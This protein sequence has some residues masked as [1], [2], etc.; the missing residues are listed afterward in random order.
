MRVLWTLSAEQDRADIIDFIA[1]NN[2]LAAVRM[3]ELF[4]AAVERLANH[5]LLGPFTADGWLAAS[6]QVPACLCGSRR[7]RLAL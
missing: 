2:P 7:V 3:D 5:P 4:A 1:E 6:V